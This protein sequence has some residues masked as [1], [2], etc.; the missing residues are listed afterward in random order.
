LCA[1]DKYMR[2]DCTICYSH[3]STTTT[4]FA[5]CMH[6]ALVLHCSLICCIAHCYIDVYTMITGGSGGLV[7]YPRLAIVTGK[8]STATVLQ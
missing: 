4:T 1:V 8:D 2:T 3:T 5:T 6:I 7:C